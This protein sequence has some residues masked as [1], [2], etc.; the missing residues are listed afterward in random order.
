MH[1]KMDLER[2]SLQPMKNAKHLKNIKEAVHAVN[3]VKER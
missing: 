1:N 2:L 3:R